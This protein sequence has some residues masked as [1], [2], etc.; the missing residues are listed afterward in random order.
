EIWRRAFQQR[1]HA[2]WE[3]VYTI[4]STQVRSWLKK[5]TG[6]WPN[7]QFDEEALL[8][9]VFIRVFRFITPEKFNNFDSLA[10]LL[11]YLKMCCLT[12]ALE[13]MRSFEATAKDVPLIT[14][15]DEAKESSSPEAHLTSQDDV[16]ETV[17][18]RVDRPAFW[19][20][21]ERRLPEKADKVAIYCRF[22][23]QMPPREIAA[24]YSQYF[25]NTEAVHRCL[26]NALWRL[27]NDPALKEWLKDF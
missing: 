22:V 23:L 8:N 24:L 5:S 2:A 12:E 18:G 10:R 20:V 7:I 11:E 16:E 17:S 26:R 3:A 27:R 25:P 14:E 21:I 13:V 4:Y 1:D 19:Q 15:V 9:G 6:R